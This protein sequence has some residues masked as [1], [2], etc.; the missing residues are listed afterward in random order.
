MTVTRWEAAREYTAWPLMLNRCGVARYARLRD[1]PR[2]NGPN[3]PPE[4][5]R[6]PY[7]R[8]GK[9]PKHSRMPPGDVEPCNRN[10]SPW[11]PA[12]TAPGPLSLVDAPTP[13]NRNPSTWT[14]ASTAPGPL[15]LVDAWTPGHRSRRRAVAAIEC[16]QFRRL[17][18]DSRMRLMTST[19]GICSMSNV[20]A[21]TRE[22][23]AMNKTLGLAILFLFFGTA[24][25]E[26]RYFVDDSTDVLETLV[27]N[28]DIAA[29]TG[30]TAV[31]RTTIEAAYTGNIYLLGTWDGTDYA[32][33]T[34]IL[35]PIDPTTDTGRVMEAAHVMMDVFDVALE[36]LTENRSTWP[37][38]NVVNAT[39]GI[40]WMHVN[41]ARIALSE[42]RSAENRIAF[43]NAAAG[44]PS[45][46]NGDARQYVD[47]DG[48]RGY[49]AYRR[50]VMGQP[51]ERP[52]DIARDWRLFQRF[53]ER[54][55]YR[56][57]AGNR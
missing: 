34:G 38:A 6:P 4:R 24:G 52:P 8:S 33:P 55:E 54:I 29:P 41:A 7:G 13:G 56:H 25:A 42:T 22:I 47:F 9:S 45:N 39:D 21:L 40:Y 35:I 48:N 15:S 28:D 44:W 11:T 43:L 16:K 14:P 12:N 36:Y 49:F 10:P 18:R 23:L 5:E 30:Q 32:P 37:A 1:E 46:A 3:A 57:H 27:T 53:S 31:A 19:Y 26:V 17:T 20:Y 51:A 2:D 50:M